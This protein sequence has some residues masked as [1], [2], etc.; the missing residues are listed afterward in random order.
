MNVK[1]IATLSLGLAVTFAALGAQQQAQAL[2]TE[3]ELRSY[4]L[5]MDIGNQFRKLSIDVDAAVF[6]KGLSDGLAGGKTLMTESEAKSAIGRVQNDFKRRQILPTVG[7]EEKL[8]VDARKVGAAFLAE[9]AKKPG[10]VTLPSGLQYKVI[11]QG[12]GRKP[13]V[14][15]TVVCQYRGT[16]VDGSE[17]DSSYARKQPATFRVN[18]VI[19]G[20]TEALQ[21][22][23]V[24]SK[25]QL[26]IPSELAYG[27][28]G[29]GDKIAPGAT[30]IFEI[31]LLSIK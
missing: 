24:G 18:G 4:A 21:L 19:P 14:T 29:S 11:V 3:R 10:V 15:D 28:Q 23:P 13:S 27:A 16:L 9:N 31:E 17:F 25:L 6:A 20:W 5:G 1:W 22:M 2:K 26:F 8:P 30:L 12:K 7:P